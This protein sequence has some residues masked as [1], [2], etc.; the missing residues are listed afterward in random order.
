MKPL[1]DDIRRMM[2]PN[3]ASKLK[4]GPWDDSLH[5][6]CIGGEGPALF[7]SIPGNLLVAKFCLTHLTPA[8]VGGHCMLSADCLAQ[9]A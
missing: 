3:T 4:V 6:V 2:M 7:H 8:S 1:E 9:P 5:P